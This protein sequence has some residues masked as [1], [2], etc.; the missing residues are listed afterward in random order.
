M[1]READ[2]TSGG[3]IRRLRAC[4]IFD[5]RY[6]ST[7]QI[8]K[9]FESGLRQAGLETVCIN[10]KQALVDS[11]KDFDLI[12]IGGPTEWRSASK[13]MKTFLHDLRKADLSGKY[14]F[15]FDTKLGRR[16]SGS[17]AEVI[18]KELKSA[19]AKV[20][21]R[22]RSATVLLRNANAGGS[23]LKEGELQRFEEIG[24]KIGRALP[25]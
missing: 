4:I 23:S 18:E 24:M 6:G 14:G 15:A 10:A 11:L 16:F 20:I 1:D 13:R 7:E 17:A 3:G 12:S 5:T 9:A 21:S 22:R 8:A 2:S 25:V 19:G